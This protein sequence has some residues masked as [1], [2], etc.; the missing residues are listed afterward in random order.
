MRKSKSTNDEDD[1]QEKN[2]I[3]LIRLYG[4]ITNDSLVNKVSNRGERECRKL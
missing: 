2:E 3:R 1:I 4:K